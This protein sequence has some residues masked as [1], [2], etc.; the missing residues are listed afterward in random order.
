MGAWIFFASAGFMLLLAIHPFATYPLTLHAL[1]YLR[2]RAIALASPT[3]G[4]PD[5]SVCLCA[6]NEAA[7]IRG[8]IDNLLELRRETGALQILVHVD[9]A[10][11]GTNEILREYGD[12]IEVIASTERR[13][14]TYGINQLMSL[15]RGEIVVLIDANV[16]IDQGALR[17]LA[18]YFRDPNVGCVCGHLIY[19]TSIDTAT[20]SIGSAYWRLEEHIKQLESDTG[21]VMGADGS[22]YALRRSLL[23][24]VPADMIDDMFISLRV[25]GDGYRV[26]RAPDV[27]AFEPSIPDSR[28]EF[29][30]KIRIACQ[31]FGA[32]LVLWPMLRRQGP[33]TVYK[34][35]SHKLIRWFTIVWL[36]AAAAFGLVGAAV[37][38]GWPIALGLLAAAGVIYAIE[39]YQRVRMLT[40]AVDA[41]RSFA[42]T[43][44]GVWRAIKGERPRTWTPAT[45]IRGEG[46]VPRTKP[47]AAPV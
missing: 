27:R 21:S 25:L 2:P 6:Y 29:R 26:V 7:V 22:L 16:R 36:A 15:A 39:S 47:P 18:R 34:Y 32:H 10:T 24:P 1:R 41:L 30:R 3:D 17:A 13:G 45:S 35:V 31:A 12:E 42:A 40:A 33:V 11:D 8:T 5:F 38:F 14:K 46:T 28:E 9:A 19:V 23:R 37:A 43:G 20:A 44:I 4:L